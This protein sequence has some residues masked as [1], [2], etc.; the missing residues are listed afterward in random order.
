M[1]GKRGHTAAGGDVSSD[2]TQKGADGGI[3]MRIV[4]RLDDD[5]APLSADDNM[6]SVRH[7]QEL[8][9]G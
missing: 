2:Q 3:A 8:A 4:Y 5:A 7:A 6:S 9:N 1:V